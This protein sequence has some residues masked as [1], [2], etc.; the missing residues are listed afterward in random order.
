MDSLTARPRRKQQSKARSSLVPE[1]SSLRDFSVNSN[2]LDTVDES[3]S[4]YLSES[5]R[6]ASLNQLLNKKANTVTFR[7]PILLR[8]SPNVAAAAAARAAAAAAAAGQQ[9]PPDASG[10][11]RNFN[12]LWVRLDSGGNPYI[13]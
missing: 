10:R 4:H 1:P 5:R 3:F 12:D 6:E 13:R 2:T 11:Y 8:T 9:H 7:P